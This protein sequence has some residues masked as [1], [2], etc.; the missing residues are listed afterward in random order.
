MTAP[1]RQRIIIAAIV[2]LSALTVATAVRYAS[3]VAGGADS[4]GYLS[5][6]LLWPSGSLTV[7]NDPIVARSPWPFPRT[8]WT[9]LGYTASPSGNGVVPLYPPGLPLL[10]AAFQFVVGYCG[11]LLVVPIAAGVAVAATFLLGRRVFA[12]DAVALSA[13]LLLASTP[14]F[15]YQA[16]NPMSDVPATAAWA[17]ALWLAAADW[18]IAAGLAASV[19][20]AIRPNLGVAA[21]PI[22]VWF[23]WQG[24]Q[25]AVR[26][27]AGLVPAVVVLAAVNRI[28]YG[29][30]LTFGYGRASDLYALG[31][32]WTNVTQ[33]ARW[34]A[35][36]QTPLVFAG[37][38]FA[39]APAMFATPLIH[40]ARL[41][42]VG[43]AAVVIASYVF[44]APFGAWWFLRFLLPAWPALMLAATVVLYGS[45]PR[46]RARSLVAAG[47]VALMC[48][49][50]LVVAQQR[51]AFDLWRGERRFVDAAFYVRD[52][53]EPQA[54]V[55]TLAHSGSVRYYAGRLTLRWD[56]LR[57]TRLD[58]AIEF[59]QSSGR[60]PYLLLDGV[61]V[62]VFRARFGEMSQLASLAWQPIARLDRPE[63]LLFDLVHRTDEPPVTMR[64][65][66][67]GSP[68]WHCDPPAPGSSAQD[69]QH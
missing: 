35:E 69:L 59:L 45:A 4:Y 14:V 20:T 22:A 53:T 68:R 57:P 67:I 30:A 8:P 11:A 10:M 42:L 7:P 29:S 43:F 64:N 18:P 58:Q 52:H 32:F 56:L 36:G 61:E 9:P 1:H 19:A 60:H 50:G 66:G 3:A 48:T 40:R 55:L 24:P 41:L 51:F 38:A 5:E 31:N 2:I 28:L 13:A 25:R 27:V 37:V 34:A 33:F 46:A 65:T 47:C 16:V 12:D 21:I 15:L 49:W 54:V 17:I 62:P 26:F 39:L 6:A 63:V 44:Y 23:V